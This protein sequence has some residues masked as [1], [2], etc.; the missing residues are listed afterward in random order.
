MPTTTRFCYLDRSSFNWRLSFISF[1]NLRTRDHI[2]F[3]LHPMKTIVNYKKIKAKE[4]LHRRVSM[5]TKKQISLNETLSFKMRMLL[6]FQRGDTSPHKEK[7][8][9]SPSRMPCSF[10]WVLH[11]EFIFNN[12]NNKT[13]LP[14]E[15]RHRFNLKCKILW[16]NYTLVA[17]SESSKQSQWDKNK[18]FF[19]RVI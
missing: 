10:S 6:T 14:I 12:F 11:P 16:S 9:L 3:Q 15:Y 18:N 13:L 2:T 19:T 8:M 1:W 5:R 7:K 4:N 17:S